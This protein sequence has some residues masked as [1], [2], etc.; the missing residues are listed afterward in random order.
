MLTCGMIKAGRDLVGWTQADLAARA[1]VSL[2]TIQRME[3]PTR[4]PLRSSAANVE[5]VRGAF[6]QGGLAFALDDAR[7]T[8]SLVVPR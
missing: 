8:I 4:G 7:I 5:R 6:A 1:G 2:P 3:D